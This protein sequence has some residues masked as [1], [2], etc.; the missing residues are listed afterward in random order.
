MKIKKKY[1]ILSIIVLLA[2]AYCYNSYKNNPKK[3]IA[4]A[5]YSL[6]DKIL[7]SIDNF[8]PNIGIKNMADK[9]S[10]SGNFTVSLLGN[11]EN[12][13]NDKINIIYTSDATKKGKY[14]YYKK[15]EDKN[16]NEYSEKIINS[17]I[18]IA[19]PQILDKSFYID[20]N[21]AESFSKN[22]N[23]SK[24]MGWDFSKEEN[25]SYPKSFQ[26]LKVDFKK[27]VAKEWVEFIKTTRVK[28]L[29]DNSFQL[30]LNSRDSKSLFLKTFEYLKEKNS[31]IFDRY[32]NISIRFN[33]LME[34]IEDNSIIILNVSIDE[35]KEIKKIYTADNKYLLDFTNGF[36]FKF[37]TISLNF[38]RENYENRNM[39]K[40]YYKG[41]FFRISYYP[42][43]YKILA[44]NRIERF[45]IKFDSLEKN[46]YFTS[47]I[48]VEGPYKYKDI[49][50]NFYA[51]AKDIKADKDFI[52]ILK[53]DDKDWQKLKMKFPKNFFKENLNLY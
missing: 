21:T 30:I 14:L 36:N 6:D 29:D 42:Q 49:K 1:I 20:K 46:Y 34:K 17:D 48:N 27:Y 40:G 32:P 28:R 51:F 24:D 39:I 23:V 12:S 13:N 10:D 11:T 5:F 37:P 18:Y 52:K 35:N 25:F 16:I 19:Y 7:I 43:N 38:I 3:I 33:R 53:I 47:K 2:S 45:Q 9:I 4:Q 31:Y 15:V 22:N 50:F 26:D 41:K 8:F 44:W